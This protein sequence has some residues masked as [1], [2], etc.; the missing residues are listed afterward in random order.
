MDNKTIAIIVAGGTGKRMGSHIPKQFLDLAGKPVIIHTLEKFE[1]SPLVDGIVIVSHADHIEKTEKLAKEHDISKLLKVV[2]GGETRQA[3]SYNG[4]KACTEGTE[5]VLIH[6]AVRPFIDDRI[7]KD[8]L[9]AARVTGAAT[10][11]IESTDTI[12]FA[13]DDIIEDIPPRSQVK[14]VQTP[15]GFKYGVILKA[16]EDAIAEGVAD[17]TDDC[18]LILVRG[19]SVKIVPGAFENLK[20]TDKIDLLMAESLVKKR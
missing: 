2:A 12:V 17:Y 13:E 8:V 15:Q 1:K 18:G 6:D 5:I 20:I 4:L 11:V 16:H 7:I 14:R 3:S 19:G 9:E 10:T